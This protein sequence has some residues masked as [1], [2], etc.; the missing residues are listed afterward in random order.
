MDCVWKFQ[1]TRYANE[2]A[3]TLRK[4]IVRI[5]FC[6]KLRNLCK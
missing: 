3:Y 4:K 5:I 2:T 1:D 6:A